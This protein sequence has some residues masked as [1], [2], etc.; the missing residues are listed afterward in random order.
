[1]LDPVKQQGFTVVEL[2]I[3]LFIAAA[4]LVS[5]YQLFSVIIK[6]GGEARMQSRAADVAYDYL[7][8]YEKSATNP[9]TV[10]TPL[11]NQS[12]TATGLSNV[13]VSVN[14]TCPYTSTTSVSKVL[15]TLKYSNPQITIT[16]AT[17]VSPD[18]T[19]APSSPPDAPVLSASPVSPA[20][21]YFSWPE[22]S[23]AD[24]YTF[25]Y[26]INSGAWVTSFT[27]QDVTSA[28]ISAYN[29]DTIYGRATAK[30]TAGT[31]SYSATA[32]ATTQLWVT[33]T[34]QNNWSNY[35][36]P[37][38]AGA[39]TKTDSG[40]VILKGL[41]KRSGSVV[42][43][44]TIFTLPEG[45]RP[46]TQQAFIV[47][48]TGTA[49]ASIQI[50][51]DGQVLASTDSNATATSLDRIAFIASDQSYSWTNL[52]M[53]NGWTNRG[54]GDDPPFSYT[55]D[56]VGHVHIRG[57]LD[58][59]TI[60]SGTNIAT[61]PGPISVSPKLI[62]AMRSGCNG[63]NIINIGDSGN[64]TPRGL[65]MGSVLYASSMYLPTTYSS[66]SSMSLQNGWVIH[67]TPANTA[68]EYTKTSDG[69]VT[70][71]GLIKNGSTSNGVV[72]T[73][74]PA[75]YRPADVLTFISACNDSAC[76]ID[77][78]PDGDVIG[79]GVSSAWTSLSGINFIAEQ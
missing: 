57:S 55:I 10:K 49:S 67:G 27:D 22:V 24:T 1:M 14:I 59:G 39:F 3:T 25:Q 26:K 70:L 51:T 32:S 73:N 34:F 30:N 8:R 72:I 16:N 68:P 4:F 42:N 46:A 63:F 29:N 28:T 37:Y 33:P 17:Y 9:C 15:V 11:N 54:S 65:C 78:E 76:R 23:G 53:S 18:P 41:L 50:Q 69:V 74:L 13:T 36:S 56:S 19:A 66:W 58:P 60:T 79:R 44:E 6:D 2:L 47:E 45:Y 7:Q 52:S 48:I 61:L 77:I 40:I 43:N 75:G 64:F 35:G 21:V 38:A 62:V 12:I 31:S 20:G 71:K 5:G